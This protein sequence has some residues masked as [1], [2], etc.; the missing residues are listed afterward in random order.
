[1]PAR[2][3]NLQAVVIRDARSTG[4]RTKYPELEPHVG[5]TGSIE[6]VH[7]VGHDNVPGVASRSDSSPNL[8]M[9]TVRLESGQL[10]LAVPEDALREPV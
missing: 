3:R 2:Y 4:G 5:Q 7:Q 10:L 1:V 8:Y 9:Y 6:R